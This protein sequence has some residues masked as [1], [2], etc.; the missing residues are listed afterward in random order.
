MNLGLWI[1]LRPTDDLPAVMGRVAAMGYSSLHAHFPAGCDGRLA[2]RVRR[3][4]AG[5]GIALAAVSGYANP[6]RP[7]EAPMGATAGQL[8]GLVELLPELHVRRLVSWSGTYGAGLLD[9]HPENATPAAWDTLRRSVAELLPALERAE[10]ALLIEPFY[11]HVLGTPERLARFCRE[12]GGPVGLVLDPPNLLPMPSWPRQE[13]LI[14][15]MC[16]TLAPYVGL[17]HLKDMRERDGQLDLPGPGQG[18]LRYP[19]FLAAL[20]RSGIGAPLIVE[21]VTLEQAAAARRFVLSAD[22]V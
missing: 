10:A 8:A 20:R 11:S 18:V 16:E 17:V 7:T 6:M 14:A 3:A 15:E 21:H 5:A 22:R 13:A 9:D 4:V 2:R 1:E 12:L 19:A